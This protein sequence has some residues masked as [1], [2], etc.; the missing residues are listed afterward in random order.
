MVRR[1]YKGCWCA[2]A[3]DC[4]PSWRKLLRFR[5]SDTRFVRLRRFPLLKSNNLLFGSYIFFSDMG[6]SGSPVR[7]FSCSLLPVASQ[8]QAWAFQRCPSLQLLSMVT[9]SLGLSFFGLFANGGWRSNWS[10]WSTS[11]SMAIPSQ[12]IFQLRCVLTTH[13]GRPSSHWHYFLL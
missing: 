6:P 7:W 8:R 10:S 13:S 2:H 12:F 3:E 9:A 5:E 11:V 1:W 4:S